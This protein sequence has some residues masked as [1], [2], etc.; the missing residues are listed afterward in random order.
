M[1]SLAFF[2]GGQ[3]TLELI[4]IMFGCWTGNA[5]LAKTGLRGACELLM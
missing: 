2:K 1:L 4:L 3:E 5:A